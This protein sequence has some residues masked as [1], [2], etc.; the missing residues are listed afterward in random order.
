MKFILIDEDKSSMNNIVCIK[1]NN[2]HDYNSLKA[3]IDWLRPYYLI[4]PFI[5]MIVNKMDD[6]LKQ[7]ETNHLL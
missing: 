2:Y 7:W 6:N 1:P 5:T 4:A 3:K